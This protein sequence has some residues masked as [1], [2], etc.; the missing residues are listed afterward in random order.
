MMAR[1]KAQLRGWAVATGALAVFSLAIAS[2]AQASDGYFA[3]GYGMKAKGRGGASFAYTDSAFGGA[4]NPATMVW[5]GNRFEVGLTVL[6]PTRSAK[7][8]GSAGGVGDFSESSDHNYF[9][10][11]EMGYTHQIND[12]WAWG[13]T[14]Y[15]NGGLNT[16]YHDNTLTAADCHV[17]GTP[18]P[19]NPAANRNSLCG[20]GRLGLNLY[21]VIIAPTFAYKFTPK[22]SIGISLL[23]G[24]QSLKMYGLQFFEPLS[25]SPQNV[26]NKGTNWSYGYGARIG[27]FYRPFPWLS[28]GGMFSTKVRMSPFDRYRGVLANGGKFDIPRNYGAGFVVKPIEILSIGFDWKRIEHT[29]VASNGN[30]ANAGPGNLLG[31]HNG[32]GQEWQDINAYKVGVELWPDGKALPI[33]GSLT[34]RAGYDHDDQVISKQAVTVNIIAPGVG[35]DHITVGFTYRFGE[36]SEITGMYMRWLDASLSGPSALPFGGRETLGMKEN[37]VGIAYARRF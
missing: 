22:M 25:N 24:I 21:Q 8:T 26:S 5:V 37:A 33:G 35:Q 10:V 3:H 9:F 28:L 2:P 11:P 19:A 29:S 17:P 14:V 1:L 36:H 30:T 7:R 32:P 4:N 18:A 15:A 20:Q 16:K 12:R 6:N 23:G 34:L 31:S 27:Y 13:V